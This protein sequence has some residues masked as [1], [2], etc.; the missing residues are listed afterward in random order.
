[1]GINWLDAAYTAINVIEVLCLGALV[2][3]VV[4]FVWIGVRDG[5]RQRWERGLSHHP[6]SCV[7]VIRPEPPKPVVFDWATQEGA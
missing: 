1:M 4:A 7:T 6:T 2:G 3:L 5:R